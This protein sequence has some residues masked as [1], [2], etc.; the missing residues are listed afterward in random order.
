[1]KILVIEEQQSV[2][3]SLHHSLSFNG[4]DVVLAHDGREGLETL[5]RHALDLVL[6]DMELPGMDGLSVCRELRS[7]G[8]ILPVVMISAQGGAD[9]RVAGLD[10]G[11]D[12][13][14]TA[15]FVL[16]EL[17]ARMGAALRRA[18]L[19]TPDQ[20]ARSRNLL[21]FKDLSLDTQNRQM[22][23]AGRV[24]ELTSTESRLLTLLLTQPRHVLSR[25][26][27]LK[28]IWGEEASAPNNGLD[29]YIGYLRRKTEAGG[30]AR[31][32]HTV[33]GVGYVL[34]EPTS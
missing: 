24:V 9:D 27:L 26:T 14:L 2:R 17:L 12:D 28:K 29:V 34:R 32:I 1:M 19:I 21:A 11:A 8:H 30:A 6:L 7:R 23:R 25:P 20:E 3:E 15:P 5:D 31:L 18:T 10:A 13:C 16:E 33:H 22:R 4:C